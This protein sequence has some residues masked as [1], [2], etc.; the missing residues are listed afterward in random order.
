MI[1]LTNDDVTG[2]YPHHPREVAAHVTLGAAAAVLVRDDGAPL[3]PGE[4]VVVT[5]ACAALVTRLGLLVYL[6]DPGRGVRPVV[7]QQESLPRALLGQGP[8]PNRTRVA[9]AGDR[10]VAAWRR[11]ATSDGSAADDS[12]GVAG[13]LALG[14]WCSWSVRRAA[15]ARTR[16]RYALDVDPTD[17]LARLV[18]GWCRTRRGPRWES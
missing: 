5:T 8:A 17:P 6:V 15:Q 1:N 16:A 2:R 3:G 10:C 7:P 4:A 9:T 18:L 12:V 11:W 13:A 14:A